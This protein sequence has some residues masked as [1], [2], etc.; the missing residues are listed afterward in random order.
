[1]RRGLCLHSAEGNLKKKDMIHA[2]SA[3]FKGDDL[4]HDGEDIHHD[5]Y[6]QPA[7][8]VLKHDQRSLAICKDDED[9]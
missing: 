4:R 3:I 2:S 8:R 9:V 1:M 5:P 7:K 6:P